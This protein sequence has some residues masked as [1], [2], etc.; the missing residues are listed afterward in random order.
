MKSLIFLLIISLAFAADDDFS[1]AQ[2]QALS[3]KDKMTKLW[4]KITEDQSELGFYST[5]TQAGIFLESM[6]ITFSHQADDFPEGRKKLIHTVGA[7]AQAEFVVDPSNGYSGV[8][9]GVET[10]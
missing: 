10:G 3:A 2:Y 9:E 7:I 1:S 8:F 5:I 6:P 4:S